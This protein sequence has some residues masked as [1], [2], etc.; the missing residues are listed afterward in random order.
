MRPSDQRGSAPVTSFHRH[1]CGISGPKG[2]RVEFHTHGVA[3]PETQIWSGSPAEDLGDSSACAQRVASGQCSVRAATRKP[4]AGT[5]NPQTPLGLWQAP[6][7]GG[8]WLLHPSPMT[9]G[10]AQLEGAG[11]CR[12]GRGMSQVLTS[13]LLGWSL[14]RHKEGCCLSAHM[15]LPPA[16]LHPTGNCSWGGQV[17]VRRGPTLLS[18]GEGPVTQS[19]TSG[20]RP[21]P[22]RHSRKKKK[23][24][25][26]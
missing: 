5:A 17:R 1:W 26:L 20:W 15:G 13:L 9:E 8:A 3:P 18:A 10:R 2:A 22:C 12:G 19:S 6:G 11:T 16:N 4:R 21:P 23:K 14:L 25:R 24:K 7:V